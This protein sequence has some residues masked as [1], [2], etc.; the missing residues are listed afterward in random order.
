VAELSVD[1]LRAMLGREGNRAEA[2][3]RQVRDQVAER[4]LL[5]L[6]LLLR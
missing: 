1:R 3:E 5:R 4:G 2:A 6:Y